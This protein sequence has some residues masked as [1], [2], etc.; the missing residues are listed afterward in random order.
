MLRPHALKRLNA[1]GIELRTSSPVTRV[2]EGALELKG[3]E[4][5]EASTIIWAAGVRAHPLAETLP[6]PHDRI[7]RAKVNEYLQ[8]EGHPEVFVI[9]DSSSPA[10][11]PMLPA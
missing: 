11:P 9:G 2:S 8:L 3:S 10:L 1:E 7:G 6:G 5:I 4:I